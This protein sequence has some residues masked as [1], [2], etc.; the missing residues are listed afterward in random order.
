MYDYIKGIY[1]GMHKEYIVVENNGIG[2]KI[3]V[4]GNTISNMPK[5]N[6]EVKLYI[7]QMVRE[8]FLGLY[9]F[10]SK[11][12]REMFNLLLTINGV[13]AKAALSLLSISSVHNLKYAIL[14]GDDKTLTRAPGVGKKIAQRIILE[15]KDK[16]KGQEVAGII[17]D[18]VED[19][20]IENNIS[21][22]L[23]ALV[24]LGYTEKEAN[25]AL[26]KVNKAETIEN[27]I[28]EALKYLMG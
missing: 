21:E 3:S 8:D 26:E 11:E 25:K 7:E 24:A 15:L 1:M 17:A 27:I 10:F 6:E 28:K 23:Q 12:E 22:S 2:Y 19:I 5:I 13:G 9:G 4:S 16:L 18:N 20:T 14:I